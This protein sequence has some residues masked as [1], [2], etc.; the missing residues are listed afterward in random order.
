MPAQAEA[1]V[2]LDACFSENSAKSLTDPDGWIPKGIPI[3]T[4]L[5]GAPLPARSG[6]MERQPPERYPYAN[7]VSLA[8]AGKAET[9]AEI[10]RTIDGLPHGALTNSLLAGLLGG[11]DTN[12]DGTMTYREMFQFVREHMSQLV[13]HS[14][15]LLAATE[16]SLE[17]PVL[18]G[19]RPAPPPAKPAP[20]TAPKPVVAAK[21]VPPKPTPPAFPEPAAVPPS[22]PAQPAPAPAARIRLKLVEIPPDVAKPL[23]SAE[24]IEIVEKDHDMMLAAVPGGFS[25]FEQNGSLVKTFVKDEAGKI[26]GRV[27]ANGPLARLRAWKNPDQLFNVRIDAEAVDDKFKAQFQ[28]GDKVK[29]RIGSERPAYLL[30]LNIDKSGNVV[31]LFPGP[32]DADRQIQSPRK[33][34]D[35]LVEAVRPAGSEH[36]KLLGFP[37]PPPQWSEWACR[38]REERGRSRT[39][40]HEFGPE[41]ERFARLLKMLDTSTGV[42]QAT[43]R[44]TTVE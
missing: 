40:C 6:P 20:S 4:L 28:A 18:G 1:L 35:F 9:A 27:R 30:L 7:V 23:R 11:G 19:T 44:V 42:A 41:Q 17:R 2:I 16:F 33:D 22:V 36:L 5:K 26:P 32:D 10:R 43:L 15:Q 12:R 8:A 25:L 21:P 34:I 24:G 29:L 3:E 39:E 31:V 14:P 37:E 13:S 38:K